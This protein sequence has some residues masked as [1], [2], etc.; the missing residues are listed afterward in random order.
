MTHSASSTKHDPLKPVIA[1]GQ[2]ADVTIDPRSLVDY[3]RYD[4]AAFILLFLSE[5]EG[6]EHGVPEFH[7]YVFSLMTNEHPRTAIAIPRDHAKTTLAKLAAVYLFIY[8]PTRFLVYASNT[9]TIAAAACRD[10]ANFIR[11]PQCTRIYGEPVFS[12]AED[13]KGNYTFE[14]RGK[15]IIIRAMGA[16]QQVRGL[17]VDN[18]RP[19]LAVV[20][21]IESA[22]ELESNKLGYE[23]LKKWFYTTFRKALDRRR[24][25][26]IQIGNLVSNRSILRDHLESPNWQS[27]RLGAFTR[28]GDVL[29]PA[30]WTLETLRMEMIEY[31]REGQLFGW[32]AE[33]LN[34]PMSEATG[35]LPADAVRIAAPL[36]PGD[37]R[38]TMRCIT[39]DPAITDNMAHA[40]AAVVVV[41]IF[42][43]GVWRKAEHKEMYGVGPYELYEEIVT[44]GLKWRARVVGVESDSYQASLLYVF[45]HESARLGVKQFIFVPTHS[46]RVAKAKRILTWVNMI[47]TGNY[48]LTINDMAVW[49]Q[50]QS[51]DVT[52][53]HNS[54]DLIDC[55]A[56][57]V[58]MI[59]RYAEQMQLAWN[60]DQVMDDNDMRAVTHD[61]KITA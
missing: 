15:I 46:Q 1:P 36:D 11:S 3:L 18:K 21:D 32:L 25:R 60:A 12:Q 55:C 7:E 22:E 43:E 14:W 23:K 38:I 13:A 40:D 4:A 47:K 28:D 37:T 29:W 19:D 26:V 52:T 16:G 51:Y 20:D 42:A 58:Q 8:S 2:Y 41:H 56:Y 50:I 57:I 6:I 35:I 5:E 48:L 10:I 49:E 27:L 34:M 45:K 30:R 39:V 31:A 24:N 59:A 61:D 54:D 9:N 17:N 44:L 53:Q 33:M